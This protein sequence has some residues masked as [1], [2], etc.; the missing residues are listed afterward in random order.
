MG[1]GFVLV[2]LPLLAIL[3]IVAVIVGKKL[4][5]PLEEIHPR[6]IRQGNVEIL[7][8]IGTALLVVFTLYGGMKLIANDGVRLLYVGF[9]LLLGPF[10]LGLAFILASRFC[11]HRGRQTA[12]IV[13]NRSGV[14]AL[15]AVWGVPG[16]FLFYALMLQNWR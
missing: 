5:L 3:T 15:H 10:L 7:G 9:V 14:G 12:A 1:V 16:G 2:Y 13:L 4:W 6:W 11:L 8:G